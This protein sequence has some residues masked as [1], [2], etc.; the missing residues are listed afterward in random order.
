MEAVKQGS[1]TVGIVVSASVDDPVLGIASL[2]TRTSVAQPLIT[3]HCSAGKGARCAGNAESNSS[4]AVLNSE[5][6]VQ[7]G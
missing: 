4:R 7:S 5:E 3:S 1:C 6:N 2:L